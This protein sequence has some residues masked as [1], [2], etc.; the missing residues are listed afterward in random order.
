M[1]GFSNVADL[2]LYRNNLFLSREQSEYYRFVIYPYLVPALLPVAQISMTASVYTTLVTCLDRYIAI[3]RPALLGCCGRSEDTTSWCLILGTAVFSVVYNI[4]RFFEY[5][6]TWEPP[7]PEKGIPFTR[8][9]K[10][11]LE[12]VVLPTELRLNKDYLRYYILLTN[13][14]FMVILPCAVM[15]TVNVLVVRAVDEANKRRAR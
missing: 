13:L 14:L 11:G 15:I 5:E 6:T 8:F 12:L 9:N 2:F 3:C 10:E 7:D 1:K 4:T